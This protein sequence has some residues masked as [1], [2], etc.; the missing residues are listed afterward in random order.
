M[1]NEA[2]RAGARLG[3][4][5][6]VFS[7]AALGGCGIDGS[8]LEFVS[9]RDPYFPETYR[10][11]FP[12]CTYQL[13]DAG[14]L[15]IAAQAG[16]A[17][18]AP[19]SAGVRELLAVDLFWR[20]RPSVTFADSTTTTATIQYV[21]TSAAGTAA[22]SGTAFVYP[23]RLKDGGLTADVESGRLRLTT[24]TGEIP[25]LLGE[26]RLSGT[27]V[28]REDPHTTVDLLRQLAL[29]AAGAAPR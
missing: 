14:D 26:A 25:E 12:L 15:H 17:T 7:A 1:T 13:D 10:V 11:D 20:P 29:H 2:R 21:V 24:R 5:A 22:Y 19:D 18:A 6:L 16:A 9:Y 23:R 28:A 8:H 3:T 4:L 27:L